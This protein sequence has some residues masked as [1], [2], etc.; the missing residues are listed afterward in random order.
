MTDHPLDL[1]RVPDSKLDVVEAV[2]DRNDFPARDVRESPASFFVAHV[3]G[4]YVGIGGF[5]QDGVDG[6]LRSVVVNRSVRGMGFGMGLC[7]K[8][9]GRARESGVETL[10]LL[11]T[12]AQDFFARLEYETIPRA[13]PPE[14]IQQT[15]EFSELCPSGATCMRKSL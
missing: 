14:A 10:S 15:S 8:L 4:Q 12:T 5:E 11:T 7:T 3:D 2:L 9:E 13:R 1:E 6:L